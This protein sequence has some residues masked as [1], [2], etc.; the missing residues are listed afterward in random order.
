MSKTSE[1][2]L[3]LGYVRVSTGI[4]VE[5]GKSLGDQERRV[6]EHCE[7]KMGDEPYELEIFREEGR[8][9]AWTIRQH[10]EFGDKIRPVLSDLI[11]RAETESAYAVVVDTVDRLSRDMLI[12]LT[13]HRA[14]LEPAGVKLLV[15]DGDLDFDDAGDE[16][17]ATFQAVIGQA[18]L[19]KM[20]HR[21]LRRHEE[22]IAAGFFAAGKTGYG[23]RWQTEEEFRASSQAFKG[24]TPV[25]EEVEWVKWIFEQYA[26]KG[27]VL[28]DICKELNLRGVPYRGS[29]KP[30]SA[31]RL[32]KILN[33]CHHAG[34][35]SDKEGELHQGA[36]HEQRFIDPDVYYAAQDIKSERATRGPRALAQ[37]DAPLVG[38]ISCAV[39][40]HRLQL[41]RD[42]RGQPLYMCPRSQEGGHCPP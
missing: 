1:R 6:R 33:N 15:I 34:L 11:E 16:M 20:S 22:R 37:R 40:G 32:R 21:T 25:D 38:V 41:G 9:G 18:E 14:H 24:I 28:E 23:W 35:I 2:K 8:S 29:D 36:H 12:W 27:R 10:P 42:Q 4:Q 26:E 7:R 30:W 39:C 5:E 19:R 17:M 31:Y 13:I 3:L